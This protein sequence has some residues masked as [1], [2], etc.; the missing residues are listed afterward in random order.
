MTAAMFSVTLARSTPTIAV[1]PR[2]G[3]ITTAVLG[4]VLGDLAQAAAQAGR[5]GRSSPASSP[6]FAPDT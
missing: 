1:S 5:D 6:A 4:H 3:S 2:S